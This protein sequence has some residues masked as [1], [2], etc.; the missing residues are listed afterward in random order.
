MKTVYQDRIYKDAAG[1]YFTAQYLENNRSII[2]ELIE[3]YTEISLDRMSWD[4]YTAEL[5][6]KTIRCNYSQIFY[7]NSQMILCNAIPE[8]FPDMWEYLENGS[9]YD[10]ETEEYS[11]IYQYYFIDDSTAQHLKEHTDEII[12][13]IEPLDVYVLG[14]THWG[15]SWT[16]C[17]ADF[18]Y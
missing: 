13:Y 3:G 12:Y 18:V 8:Q 4:E 15:T 5:T 10:E 1:E 11:E 17:G 2:P 14:V 7:P 16:H 9:D 6:G